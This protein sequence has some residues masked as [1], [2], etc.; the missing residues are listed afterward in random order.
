MSLILSRSEPKVFCIGRN[1]TGTTSLSK[2]LE[3]LGYIVGNQAKAELL[4]QEYAK[5]EFGPII[6]YCK[7]AQAFQDVPFSLPYLYIVLDNAFPDS[8]FILSI[9]KNEAEWYQSVITFHKNRYGINRR[10]QKG[11]LLS[12]PYR[13]TG[14]IW[15]VN[16]IVYGTPENDPY[17]ERIIK[18]HYLRHNEDVI[19]YFKFRDNLH[20]TNLSERGSYQKFCQF[21]GRKPVYDDFPWLK[22]SSEIHK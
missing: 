11:D 8:K 4:I 7:K 9:R 22:K 19:N 6:N 13:Y 14:F 18:D 20:I 5:R 2:A 1:K 10:P 16:R 17:N 12:Y 3:D 21:L 15:E